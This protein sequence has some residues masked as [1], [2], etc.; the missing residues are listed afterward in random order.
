MTRTSALVRD[1]PQINPNSLHDF[2]VAKRGPK[3]V[4]RT[5]MSMS[6]D[7]KSVPKKPGH[8]YAQTTNIKFEFFDQRTSNAP[9]GYEHFVSVP[10]QYDK[11]TDK[12]WPLILFLHG[13][14]ESQRGRNESFVSLRHGIPKVIL[15]YNRFKS[16]PSNPNPSPSISIPPAERFR[17]TEQIK[18]GDQSSYPVPAEVCVLLAENFITVSPSLN[19]DWG[20]GWNASIL[21]ALLDEIVQRYRVDL[22]RIHVTGF[23]MGGYGTWELGLHTPHRFATLMP[24]CGGGDELRVSHI[25]HIPH[26]AQHGDRDDI[27]PLRASQKM[28]TALER[29][30]APEVRFTRYPDLMHDSWTAAYNNPEVYRWMLARQRQVKGDE[31]GVP[32]ENKVVLS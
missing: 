25:K 23:S 12:K 26:W 29:A 22:D 3:N 21:T 32:A 16:D 9:F 8:P 15:C 19:M 20:Y 5:V 7:K 31:Q 18:Q 14:G 10:P 11:D 2:H 6:T 28:V 17:K 30:G 13:A 27:I 1:D 24:V 4:P